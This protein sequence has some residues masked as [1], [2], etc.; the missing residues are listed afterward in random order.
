MRAIV[1]L[2]LLVMPIQ[3]QVYSTKSFWMTAPCDGSDFVYRTNI[4][5]ADAGRGPETEGW[6][7]KPWLD[8]PIKILSARIVMIGGAQSQWMMI[9]LNGSSGDSMAWL[10]GNDTQSPQPNFPAGT[11]KNFPSQKTAGSQDYID[12]HGVCS[13]GPISFFVDFG[14]VVVEDGQ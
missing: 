6:K 11:W 4:N 14:Y 5:G 2:L 13:T 1:L 9:G 3:A 7:I 10:T 12:V 8:R